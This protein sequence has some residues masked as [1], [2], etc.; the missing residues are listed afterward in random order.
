MALPAIEAVGL[1][2]RYGARKALDGV[3]LTVAEGEIL[4]LLGPNGAGKT[5]FLEILEGLR[6]ADEG[7]ARVLGEDPA[8]PRGR[9]RVQERIG[10]SLQ[11]TSLF[12]TLTVAETLE[13]FAALYPRRESAADL[14]ARMGIADRARVRVGELSGGQRQRVVLALALV[15]RPDLVFLDEPTTG[16]DPVARRYVWDSIRD[17]A[18]RGQTIVLTTHY[19][20]EATRLARHVAIMDCGRIVAEGTPEGIV[21]ALGL[22][23]RVRVE[24][25][26]LTLAGEA[27]GVRS[28]VAGDDGWRIEAD[29][30]EPVVEWVFAQAREQGV[31]IRRLEVERATLEDAFVHLTG[32]DLA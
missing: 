1:C 28:A 9:R 31:D 27:V 16:L 32:R 7:R 12:D 29:R 23:V 25:P 4:A 15:N 3:S 24:A 20:E 11:S 13:L 8:T 26:G 19:M 21:S 2:K 17:I 14:M 10:V 18:E 22:G 5:T 6:L 30:A